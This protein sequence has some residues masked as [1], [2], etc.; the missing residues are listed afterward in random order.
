MRYVKLQTTHLE[1]V[2]TPVHCSETE[3]QSCWAAQVSHKLCVK[4][5][6]KLCIVMPCLF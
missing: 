6:E 3:K 1:I 4:V 2:C 5:H